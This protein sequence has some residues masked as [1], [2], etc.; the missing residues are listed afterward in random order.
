MILVSTLS[1]FLNVTMWALLTGTIIGL[2][3]YPLS[4]KR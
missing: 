1:E 4:I 2:L 3:W